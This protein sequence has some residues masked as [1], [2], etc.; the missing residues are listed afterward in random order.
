MTDP[1]IPDSIAYHISDLYITELDR[2]LSAPLDPSLTLLETPL[3]L[4]ALLQPLL[5]TLAVAPTTTL[6]ARLADNG[7]NPLL[8]AA[9]PPAPVPGRKRKVEAVEEADLEFVA[10]LGEEREKTGRALVRAL[11]EEGGKKETGEVARRRIYALVAK[12]DADV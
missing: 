7:F 5:T 3:P 6:F 10:I 11:F 9:L 1:A 4:T 2:S 12:W 8:A